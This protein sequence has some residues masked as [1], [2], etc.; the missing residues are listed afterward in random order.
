MK[1]HLL[2]LFL[3]L[4]QIT[5]VNI[6]QA[7]I[8]LR[9]KYKKPVIHIKNV[10][11]KPG[12]KHKVKSHY[13]KTKRAKKLKKFKKIKRAKNLK[14]IKRAKKIKALKKLIKKMIRNKA[15]ADRIKAFRALKAKKLKIAADTKSAIGTMIG[16]AQSK[17]FESSKKRTNELSKKT[18]NIIVNLTILK[19]TKYLENLQETLQ[20][21]NKIQFQIRKN[22][23]RQIRKAKKEILRLKRMLNMTEDK[24]TSMLQLPGYNENPSR[25]RKIYN[26]ME[27]EIKTI[28]QERSDVEED[29]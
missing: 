17:G 27:A 16:I 12:K 22:I 14:K 3:I 23:R 10:Y 11:I 9:L 29:I 26:E 21:T 24:Y 1:K 8:K 5:T 19:T 7:R 4:L 28:H 2:S 20:L 6:I 25:I 18:F 15:K 13:S